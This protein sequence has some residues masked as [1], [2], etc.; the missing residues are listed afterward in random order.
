MSHARRAFDR[1][2]NLVVGCVDEIANLAADGL[3]PIGRGVDVGVSTR[4]GN[5]GHAGSTV[6]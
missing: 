3:L 1:F 4:V 5:V 2:G 6:T